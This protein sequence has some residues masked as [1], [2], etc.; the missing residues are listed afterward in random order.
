MY[1]QSRAVLGLRQPTK[2]ESSLGRWAIA[3]LTAPERLPFPRRGQSDTHAIWPDQPVAHA[4][5]DAVE[6]GGY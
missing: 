2:A 1:R 3:P 4:R 6:S 5:A